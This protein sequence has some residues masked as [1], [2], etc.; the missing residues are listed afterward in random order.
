MADSD[1]TPDGFASCG[2]MAP[3]EAFEADYK[4]ALLREQYRSLARLGPYV[5]LL[6]ILSTAALCCATARTS[7]LIAGIVLPSALL[8]VSSF[9]LVSWLRVR[10]GVERVALDVVRREVAGAKVL[11][12]ALAFALALMASVSTWQSSVV[13]FALALVAVWV[14]VTAC[15]FCLNALGSVASIVVAAAT[16]PLIVAFLIRGTDLTLWLAGLLTV[17]GCFVI[18]MLGENSRMFAEIVRSRFVVAEKQRAAEDARR[19]AMAIALTDDLTGLPNRRCLQGLLADR[20]RTGADIPRPFA[21]G[22]IDLDGFKPINDAHGHPAGDDILRQVA[23]RLAKTMDGRGS[24]AR[25]GGDE[26]SVL[27][28]GIDARDQAIALGKEIQAIF[29]APFAV[30]G[31]D[32]A[33][34]SACGFALFPFSAAEPDDLVRLADAALYRAKAIGHG[35]VAVFEATA[36]RDGAGRVELEEARLDMALRLGPP[37]L[38]EGIEGQEQLDE[39]RLAGRVVGEGAS[40]MGAMAAG[41]MAEERCRAA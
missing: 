13:E 8:A 34:T 36:E 7:S 11:G 33:L 30:E 1:V 25:V 16:T 4:S 35:G 2:A 20:I 9:R 19:A 17:A 27:W 37:R 3:G 28:D 15:A 39:L 6:V 23:G 12:T 38:A 21:I 29:A 18:R 31:L 24:A 32:I 22:L 10:P 41:P 14:S 26:F 5:H 40:F